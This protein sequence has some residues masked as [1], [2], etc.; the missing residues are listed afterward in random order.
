MRARL[1]A[2]LLLLLWFTFWCICV[3]DVSRD[4]FCGHPGRLVTGQ[5]FDSSYKRGKPA[6]FAPNQVLYQPGRYRI[7]ILT[8]NA[9]Y[10]RR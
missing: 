2:L 8:G 1:C 6:T 5:V 10:S 3:T 9:S 4:A 7:I